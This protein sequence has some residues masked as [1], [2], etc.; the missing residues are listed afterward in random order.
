MEKQWDSAFPSQLSKNPWALTKYWR[1]LGQ[2]RVQN[3]SLRLKPDLWEELVSR[4]SSAHIFS[5][6][7]PFTVTWTQQYYPFFFFFFFP[8]SVTISF[9]LF[10]THVILLLSC[11]IFDCEI[12]V[13]EGFQVTK[14]PEIVSSFWSLIQM[15]LW[16]I[17]CL[18]ILA[19]PSS[20]QVLSS[21]TRNR[22][23]IQCGGSLEF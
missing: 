2:I 6:S 10:Y 17:V 15:I 14:Y 3:P 4:I 20:M 11:C 19:A 12:C 13:V 21:P 23:H 22:T 5:W 8:P 7:L 1:L 9:F 16:L 18:W